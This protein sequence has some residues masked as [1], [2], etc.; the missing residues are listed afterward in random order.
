MNQPKHLSVAA[1]LEEIRPLYDFVLVRRLDDDGKKDG[2]VILPDTAR[3]PMKPGVKQGKVIAC[4]A[5]DKSP[6]TYWSCSK[7]KRIWGIYENAFAEVCNKCG[8]W[9]TLDGCDD[10]GRIGMH[11]KPGDTVLY[12][13]A[14][15]NNVVINGGEYVFLHEE[16]QILAVI[17]A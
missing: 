11:V 6:R 17:E 7:C 12:Q 3:N 8:N 15:A 16:S 10:A 1:E 13:R 9:A 2:L 5:G 14:P 4:G